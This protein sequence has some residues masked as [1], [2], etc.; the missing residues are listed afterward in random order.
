MHW[1]TKLFIFLLAL[2]TVLIGYVKFTYVPSDPAPVANLE[3]AALPEATES[4]TVADV[5]KVLA[6]SYTINAN[7]PASESAQLEFIQEYKP[8]MVVLFG[9]QISSASA[10]LAI[11]Q[12]K[13]AYADAAY[14]PIIAVDHEGGV[15]QRL[16]GTGF[17][18]LPSWQVLCHQERQLRIDQLLKSARELKEVGVNMVFAPVLD[19][20][21]TTSPLGTRICSNDPTLTA[22]AATD[23]I[24]AF[25][26][27]GITSVVKHYPGIGTTTRDL[28]DSP[29][30]IVG[31]QE[32]TLFNA[33]LA[34]SQNMGVMTAHVLV[35]NTAEDKPC[36]LSPGC[37]YPLSIDHPN[38]LI[39]T[40]AIE[41]QSAR[42]DT[43]NQTQ[44]RPLPAIAIDAVLAGNHVIMLG[45]DVPK[46]ELEAVVERLKTEYTQNVDVRSNIR[47]SVVQVEKMMARY[48]QQSETP[49]N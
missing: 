35:A 10:K 18:R 46:N 49:G 9:T 40:D 37:I 43:E 34:T 31:T 36:S 38:A 4:V 19:L 12:I 22:G 41:M 45:S 13:L 16:N 5:T 33:V 48:E 28:H 39:V 24:N 29:D 2:L 32:Q 25:L 42:F 14:Q 23:F 20:G 47:T 3:E 8:G 15:V 1:R 21:N 44:E 11:Q 17:T 27:A 30:T 7:D 6:T 26:Q